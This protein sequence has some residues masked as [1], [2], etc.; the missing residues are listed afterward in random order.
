MK[1]SGRWRALIV[2]SGLLIL[3]PDVLSAEDPKKAIA[4]YQAEM[5]K[6][7][8]SITVKPVELD[9]AVVRSGE[10]LKA[11]SAL[12]NNSSSNF[13]IPPVFGT[14]ADSIL[15]DEDWF[16]RRLDGG[17]KTE[18]IRR[19]GL[20]LRMAEF[21]AG[22][23]LPLTFWAGE[24][25]PK[26]ENL[27]TGKYEISVDLVSTAHKVVGTAAAVFE[28]VNPDYVEPSVLARKRKQEG[29]KLEVYGKEIF[30][31]LKLADLT[32]STSSVK[33]GVSVEATCALVNTSKADIPLPD[34]PVF[35]TIGKAEKFDK[36]FAII[37]MYQWLVE[38]G[39]KTVSGAGG[40]V[41]EM[42]DDGV[43]PAGHEMP[44]KN[45]IDTK[46]LPPGQYEITLT[47]RD[48]G[49][50]VFGVKKQKLRVIN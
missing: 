27:A 3:A 8:A 25:D 41:F 40:A 6:I 42:P 7:Y 37:G 23:T 22:E 9:K 47:I 48:C 39:G 44:F 5:A 2:I 50:K 29:D 15:G 11:T 38:K 17:K 46:D 1:I 43:F 14:A 13:V 20:I 12:V 18:R 21:K 49:N 32:L 30:A 45:L 33:R 34:D 35:R 26:A 24:V 16:I 19:H 10:R 36:K 28:V 31:K 4:K